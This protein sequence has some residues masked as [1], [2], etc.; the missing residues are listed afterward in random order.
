MRGEIDV[1]GVMTTQ[2][3]LEVWQKRQ[4]REAEWVALKQWWAAERSV[5]TATSQDERRRAKLGRAHTAWLYRRELARAW[6]K[7]RRARLAHGHGARVLA[8]P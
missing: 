8:K 6:P 7:S 2:A 1:W 5:R 4:R 3:R